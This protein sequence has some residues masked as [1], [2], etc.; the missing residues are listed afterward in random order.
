MAKQSGFTL[1]ELMV[2]VAVAAILLGLAVPSFR[3]TVISNRLTAATNEFMAAVNFARS[4]AIK[5]NE[6]VI[7][8]KTGTGTSCNVG[9]NKWEI[10]WMAFVDKVKDGKWT[11][12][13]EI[14]RVWPALP[15]KYTLRPNNNF[16]DYL[17]YDPHGAAS[18]IGTFAVCYDN[19]TVGAKAI[20]ITRLRPR[21]GVDTNG[22]RIPENDSGDIPSC[23]TL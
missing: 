2:T 23:F 5:R 3:E 18:N 11:S 10:G 16:D 14:L 9:G 20:I 8:C 21:L 6:T 17:R 12:G 7:L 15:A 4:E 19:Q 1:P 22:N 13:D